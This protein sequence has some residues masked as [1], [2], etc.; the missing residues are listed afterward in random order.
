LFAGAGDSSPEVVRSSESATTAFFAAL[1]GPERADL[2]IMGAGLTE[3][4]GELWRIECSG[5]AN[6]RMAGYM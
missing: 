1:G 4:E 3:D 6:R 5:H 2:A